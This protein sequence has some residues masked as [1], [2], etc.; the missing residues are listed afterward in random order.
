MVKQILK[1]GAS[2]CAPCH[3]FEK[4]LDKVSQ[5]DEYKDIEFKSF[6]IEED[7]ESETL[8]EKYSVRNVPTTVLLDENGEV[9]YKVI[10]NVSLK[11]FTEVINNAMEKLDE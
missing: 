5:M 8:V 1:F 6:D 11:D 4:T 7:E 3:L 10:G 2:W 9:I